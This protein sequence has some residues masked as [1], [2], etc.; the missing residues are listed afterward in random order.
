MLA[1]IGIRKDEPD[2]PDGEAQI[3]EL[4]RGDR[5]ERIRQP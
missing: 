4:R 2:K 5:L 3:R 1:L